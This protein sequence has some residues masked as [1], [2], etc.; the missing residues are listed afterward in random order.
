[1]KDNQVAHRLKNAR[2]RLQEIEEHGLEQEAHRLG[3]QIEELRQGMD[4]D[5]ADNTE[6]QEYGR[7]REPTESSEQDN[8]L[9]QRWLR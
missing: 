5:L 6:Q 3:E 9:V 2:E 4:E 8:S 7:A 1:M